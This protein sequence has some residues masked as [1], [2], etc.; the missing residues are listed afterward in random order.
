MNKKVELKNT[1]I[2]DI[3]VQAGESPEKA[4]QIYR[5]H[6]ALVVRGLYRDIV[7]EI[8]GDIETAAQE[9]ISMVDRA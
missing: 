5:D 1:R 7:E 2:E 9:A 6:G 3:E 8:H 4:A